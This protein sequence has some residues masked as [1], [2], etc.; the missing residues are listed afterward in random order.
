MRGNVAIE[1]KAW[2]EAEEHYRR[3]LVINPQ[4]W[5]AMNNLG[6]ALQRQGREQEAIDCFHHAAR[7]DPTSHLTQNNLLNAVKHH[8]GDTGWRRVALVF[9]YGAL[10]VLF[11]V[12]LAASSGALM[13]AIGLLGS[14]IINR[15][16]RRRKL[17]ALPPAVAAFYES[18]KKPRRLG[19]CA[20]V[21]AVAC[22][23]LLL[24][25]VFAGH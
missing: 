8:L 9:L 21:I 5:E 3:A 2:R 12:A 25:L 6:V 4:H 23:L 10:I 14:R 22:I 20:I 1:Q 18:Q 19:K 16:Q 15:P 24:L 11:V 17:Q 7:I 13:F